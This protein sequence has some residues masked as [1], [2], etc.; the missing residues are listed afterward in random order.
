MTTDGLPVSIVRG[1]TSRGV[2]LRIRD[3]PREPSERDALCVALIGSPDPLAVD[4]LGGGASSNSKIMA[5]DVPEV[6]AGL[7]GAKECPDDVDLVTLFVQVDPRR[8]DVDLSGNCGNLSAAVSAYALSRGLV[9]GVGERFSVRVWNMNTQAV[10]ELEH[11]LSG[12]VLPR[13]GDFSMPGVLTAGPRIDMR[14]EAPG[15]EQTGAALPCGPMS[16]LPEA[17]LEAS[18]VDITNP[19]VL[20]RA[21]DLG[22][23]VGATP[24]E[25]NVRTEVLDRLEVLRK[26]AGRHMGLPASAAIPRVSCLDHA[27]GPHEVGVRTT[28][29]GVFHHAIPVTA[30]IA[31]G[32]ASAL[33]GTLLDECADPT[34]DGD[35]LISQPQGTVTTTARASQGRVQS[36]GIARNARIVADA[37]VHPA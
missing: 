1:G 5:V 19:L 9:R 23:P 8:P 30:A 12:G 4:G 22:L 26:E 35:L 14:F 11:V 10:Y 36:A 13:S 32:G 25:L 21:E 29:L 18:L 28:S 7:P 34:P 17:G 6:I 27:E 2:F 37:V 16:F 31:L 3:L 20:V 15:G 24:E 33:G